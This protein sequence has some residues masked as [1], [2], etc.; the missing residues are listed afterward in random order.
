MHFHAAASEFLSSLSKKHFL[1]SLTKGLWC[2]RVARSFR[3]NLFV[4][5]ELCDAFSVAGNELIYWRA[6]LNTSTLAVIETFSQVSCSFSREAES[7]TLRV[8]ARSWSCFL[9]AFVIAS[10]QLV[11]SRC[12]PTHRSLFST[13]SLVCCCILLS[14]IFDFSWLSSSMD[15]F[16]CCWSVN[17]DYAVF[18]RKR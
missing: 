13:A 17:F 14:Y 1:L 9:I 7:L 2:R 6:R 18:Y 5:D 10:L 4:L 15:N 8:N 3:Q 11:K 16:S 12:T